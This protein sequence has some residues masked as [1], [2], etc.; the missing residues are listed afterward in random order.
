MSL[1]L[2]C[3]SDLDVPL[4][5]LDVP[6]ADLDVPLSDLDVPLSDLD[7]PLSD[8]DVRLCAR[9]V[10]DPQCG[11]EEGAVRVP[12]V[13]DK[14]PAL[15]PPAPGAMAP[16]PP[17]PSTQTW[18]HTSQAPPA[19]VAMAP[20]PPPPG[21]HS[22]PPQAP[23]RPALRSSQQLRLSPGRGPVPSPPNT[24]PQRPHMIRQQQPLPPQPAHRDAP[25]VSQSWWVGVMVRIIQSR[26]ERASPSSGLR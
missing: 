20:P 22:Y 17:P 25:Q 15:Q 19:P 12:G 14:P 2:M 3:L 13:G 1:T 26:D 9:C 11:P 10:Q 4:S 23:P 8:L 16:P 24:D 6:L 21:K 5:D 7:V 18:P